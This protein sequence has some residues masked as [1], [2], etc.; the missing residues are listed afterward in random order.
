SS[1][2]SNG[3]KRHA[4]S[5]EIREGAARGRRGSGRV[6]AT[7]ERRVGVSG[8]GAD[9]HGHAPWVVRRMRANAHL[10]DDDRRRSSTRRRQDRRDQE[11]PH[12]PRR[13]QVVKRKRG[14][15]VAGDEEARLASRLTTRM[16]SKK[17]RT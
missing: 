4:A 2:F 15:A 6:P 9:A 1:V 10:D 8:G 12:R 16:H 17:I 7:G 13:K 5:A 14:G 3:P 11:P